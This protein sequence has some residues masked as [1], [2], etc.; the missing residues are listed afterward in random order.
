MTRT[1][2]RFNDSMVRAILDG[3]KTQTRRV[4]KAQPRSRADI[5]I[6]GRGLPFIRV[7]TGKNEVCPYGRPGALVWVRET[8]QEFFADELPAGRPTPIAGRMGIPAQPE[9]RAVVAYRE[10]GEVPPHPEHGEAVWAPSCRMPRWAS[11]LTLRLKGIGIERL[12]SI[13]D[14]DA[15]AEGY[16][17][18]S[19][20]LAGE[21][22]APLADRN[23]YVWVLDF[24]PIHANVDDV[25]AQQEHA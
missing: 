4:V 3:R 25:I 8:W 22:A 23:P 14:A 6:C 12:R 10:D 15:L 1:C 18:A 19:A 9:R 5:G 13:T 17:S 21:W 7:S 24:D 20:F 11:R 16:S 2:I